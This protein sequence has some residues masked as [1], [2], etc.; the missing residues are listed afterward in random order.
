MPGKCCKGSHRKH[1][2]I[3]SKAQFR[4]MEALTARGEISPKIMRIHEIEARRKK[5]PERVRK[6]K[7]WNPLPK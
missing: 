7:K 6:H 3:V 1:T 2:P 5:L 4:K